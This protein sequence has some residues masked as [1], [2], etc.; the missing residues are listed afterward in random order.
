MLEASLAGLERRHGSSSATAPRLRTGWPA[1]DDAL[2]GGLVLHGVHEWFGIASDGETRSFAAPGRRR[3]CQWL[4]PLS[5]LVHLAWQAVDGAGAT[6]PDGDSDGDSDGGDSR[7]TAERMGP[8]MPAKVVLWIGRA[9]WPGMRSMTRPRVIPVPVP[10]PRRDSDRHIDMQDRT[11]LNRSLLLDAHDASE[12]LW[13][14]DLGLRCPAVAAVIADASGFDMGATRRLQ[15]AAE[16][17]G[18]LAILARPPWELSRLSAASTRWRVT[19]VRAPAAAPLEGRATCLA[20]APGTAFAID[21]CGA[22]LPSK[23]EMAIPPPSVPTMTPTSFRVDLLRCKGVRPSESGSG[24][25][26]TTDFGSV[27]P[28]GVRCALLER[29]DATG[30]LRACAPVADRPHSAAMVSQPQRPRRWPGE[31]SSRREDPCHDASFSPI[32]SHGGPHADPHA[33][34][35]ADPHAKGDRR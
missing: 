3:G 31:T 27:S 26:G 10:V 1:I 30:G 15:L 35:R 11:L 5:V 6:D 4:P 16:A 21:P 32:R 28:D 24:S 23:A 18:A 12:R 17:G 20:S 9:C 25:D 2:G 33:D 7:R 13:A 34:P 19:A 8:A 29:D 14:I 22:H